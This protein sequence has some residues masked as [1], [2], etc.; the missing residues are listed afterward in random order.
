MTPLAILNA[1]RIGR[2]IAFDAMSISRDATLIFSMVLSFALPIGFALFRAR[3][4][5]LALDTTGIADV[6]RYAAPLVL[7]LPALLIGWV[8]GFLLLE[9]RD[10]N[11]LTAIAVTPLGKLGFVG[12]RVSVTAAVVFAIVAASAP[13]VIPAT[14]PWV[15]LLIA[16]LIAAESVMVAAILPAIARNKVEGLALTKVINIAAVLP[17]VAIVPS[18]WRYLAGVVPSYWVG[19]LLALSSRSYLSLAAAAV[20]AV[21]VHAAAMT[22]ALRLAGRTGG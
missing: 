3:L 2:L 5:R 4:N 8:T 16:L 14:P 17:F 22:A 1:R 15:A 11:T 13:L 7:I 19:E 12:Y 18:P 20:I 6:A 21:A 9:D 10:D